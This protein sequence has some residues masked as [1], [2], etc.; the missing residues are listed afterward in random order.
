MQEDLGLEGIATVV[1]NDDA[2]AESVLAEGDAIDEGE[3]VGPV[4]LGVRAERGRR[5]A[6]VELDRR[7]RGP[8]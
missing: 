7:V 3:A 5:Q 8:R 4:R 6:E 2:S 1:G